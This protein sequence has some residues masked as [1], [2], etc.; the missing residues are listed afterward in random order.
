MLKLAGIIEARKH[1]LSRNR[2]CYL[3]HTPK[4]AETPRS[5]SRFY[6]PLIGRRRATG[7]VWTRL[8]YVTKDIDSSSR[9]SAQMSV[10][11]VFLVRGWNTRRSQEILV[12]V[13]PLPYSLLESAFNGCNRKFSQCLS[14]ITIFRCSNCSTSS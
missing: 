8:S 7:E 11:A 12:I 10:S 14:L 5:T 2:F 1:S 9:S 3:I 13:P 6:L 4:C